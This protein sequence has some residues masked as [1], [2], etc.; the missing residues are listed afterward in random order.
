ML[1]AN[2]D[3]LKDVLMY[4][5]YRRSPPVE[6]FDMGGPEGGDIDRLTLEIADEL[7]N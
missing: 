2:Y 3:K 7:C 4:D 1:A 6:M 5:S